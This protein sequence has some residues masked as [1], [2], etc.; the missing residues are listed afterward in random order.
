M[1]SL[2]EHLQGIC[3]SFQMGKVLFGAIKKLIL[4]YLAI[5]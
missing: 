5:G 1:Q 3:K 4:G 2:W